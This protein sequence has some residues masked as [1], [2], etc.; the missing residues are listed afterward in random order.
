MT[1]YQWDA[2]EYA[3]SSAG[4]Q[5]WAHELIVKLA[6]N[7]NE[8]LLDIGCGDGKISAELASDLSTGS[9]QGVDNS[10]EMIA[11]AKSRYPSAIHPN[12][13]FRLADASALPFWNEFD[14]V[15]SN[16]VLHWVNDHGPVL[17]GIADSLRPGGRILLQMGGR[18]N[19][20]KVIAAVDIVRSRPEWCDPFEGFEFPYGFYGA[21]E[22]RTWLVNAGLTPIRVELLKKVMAHADRQAFEGWLRTTW[23]PY[24]QRIDENR[25]EPFLQQVAD[26]YLLENPASADGVVHLAMVR[27]EVEAKKET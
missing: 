20:A 1:A 19:A 12:L 15:F 11:M 24:T 4:Q 23:I 17:K 3:K 22:Y 5:Q 2:V 9:V 6:L 8:R 25:R 26:Q 13:R 16:A 14:V 21:E 18:G 7:G 27:L 10:P